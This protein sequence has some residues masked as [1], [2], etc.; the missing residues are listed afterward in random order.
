MNNG[1]REY[2]DR[3]SS[4]YQRNCKIPIRIH[5][6]NGAPFEDEL[7]ILGELKGK[8]ILDLGCG[9]GQCS[10]AMAQNGAIVTGIDISLEQ[11]AFAK[12]LAVKEKAEV[13][14]YQHDGQNLHQLE[15]GTYD[16]VFSAWTL[17]YIEDLSECFKEVH[18]VL[19]SKGKFIFSLPHPF[20]R[21]INPK[22][23]RL[24]ES[25]FE[26]G[27]CEYYETLSDG[28]RIK[29]VYFRHTF[30]DVLNALINAE[31][32]LEGVIEP[33]SRIHYKGDPWYGKWDCNPKL[34]HYIPP[35]IIF[36]TGKRP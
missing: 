23:L 34:M 10:I 14:F 9:G 30:S 2:W 19:K 21:T 15:D 17:L 31:I 33:D 22:T 36:K 18:R 32:S 16:I 13:H 26:N 25:Y 7:K 8:N 1:I 35:T 6:G 28:F 24:K 3:T 20:Y 27:R 29:F 5:Y 4:A 12:E 11:I